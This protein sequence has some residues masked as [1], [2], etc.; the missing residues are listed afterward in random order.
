MAT[1]MHG[2]FGEFFLGF[3]DLKINIYQIFSGN[4]FQRQFLDSRLLPHVH[5]VSQFLAGS[6]YLK[7]RC[8]KDTICDAFVTI[9]VS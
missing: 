6:S 2:K 8:K 1:R 4:R 9:Y 5:I 3:F 7:A